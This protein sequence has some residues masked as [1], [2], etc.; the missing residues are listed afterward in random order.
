MAEAGSDPKAV[1]EALEGQVNELRGKLEEKKQERSN[2]IRLHREDADIEEKVEAF[3]Q[4]ISVLQST[5]TRLNSLLEAQ[6]TIA[7]G[8]EKLE[9]ILSVAQVVLPILPKVLADVRPLLV[10]I[11]KPLARMAIDTSKE[12][13]EER[14]DGAV[15][16]AKNKFMLFSALKDA[17]FT[18]EQ[19]MEILLA[20]IHAGSEMLRT[21]SQSKPSLPVR[22]RSRS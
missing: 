9:L 20:S 4:E 18:D 2:Y 21:L 12:L 14:K 6:S 5:Y 19:A 11:I 3:N 17:G 7:E 13:E 10:G 15:L 16:Y 8:Q 1:L 22:T